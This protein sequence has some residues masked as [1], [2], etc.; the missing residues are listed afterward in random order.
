MPEKFK[1]AALFLRLGL[2][3]VYTRARKSKDNIHGLTLILD[4]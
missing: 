4:D 3:T 2:Y 1:K